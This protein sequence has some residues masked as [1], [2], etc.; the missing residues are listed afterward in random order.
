MTA[1]PSKLEDRLYKVGNRLKKPIEGDIRTIYDLLER[2]IEIL[3]DEQVEEEVDLLESLKKSIK[4][5]KVDI[6][7]QPI[8]DYDFKTL[9]QIIESPKN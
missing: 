2:L 7:T 3:G 1:T 5:S 9:K 4:E 8:K 6:S